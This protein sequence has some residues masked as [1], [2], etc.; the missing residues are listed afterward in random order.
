MNRLSAFFSRPVPLFILALLAP[1]TEASVTLSWKDNSNNEDGFSIERSSDG[2]SFR[3]IARVTRDVVEFVDKD[4]TEGNTFHYRVRA[5][6]AFGHSGY[7]N[8]IKT[9]IGKA[10]NTIDQMLSALANGTSDL[11]QDGQLLSPQNLPS[12]AI[13]GSSLSSLHTYY[14]SL[15]V[16]FLSASGN[17][18]GERQDTFSYTYLSTDETSQIVV[19]VPYL[20]SENPTDKC[21]IMFRSSLAQDSPFAAVLL[22]GDGSTHARWR[23]IK[24]AISKTRQLLGTSQQA[25]YLKIRRQ[26]SLFRFS[27]SHDGYDWSPD[28]KVSIDLGPSPLLGLFLASSQ[29]GNASAAIEVLE[30]T[31]P[32]LPPSGS[33]YRNQRK[34]SSI[35]LSNSQVSSHL[36]TTTG[37]YELTAKGRGFEYD[38]DQINFNYWTGTSTCRIVTRIHAFKADGSWARTG[39]ALRSSLEPDSAV[40]A[41]T[42]NG[43]GEIETLTRSRKGE[44]LSPRTGPSLPSDCYLALERQGNSVVYQWSADGATWHTFH[45]VTIELPDIHHVGL[46]LGSHDGSSASLLELI[47]LY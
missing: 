40:A 36:D 32:L 10:S 34:E 23:S 35:G 42:L 20:S 12:K 38:R 33:Y 29:G 15:G 17:G 1:L 31:E 22:S 16:H 14:E 3:E 21:G 43:Y 30:S 24:G 41:V 7:T 2:K 26:G 45:S 13:G 27:S 18:L 47:G 8:T 9:V 11:L 19:E 5:F 46:A 25:R 39:L 4:A 37:L 44:R 6:N 28:V